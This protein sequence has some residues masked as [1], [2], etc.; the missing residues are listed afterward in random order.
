LLNVTQAR[1]K[2]RALVGAVL[3]GSAMGLALFAATQVGGSTKGFGAETPPPVLTQAG[4]KPAIPVSPATEAAPR[5]IQASILP[6]IT[7]SAATLRAVDPFRGAPSQSN[8]APNARDLE[9]LTEAIYFESRGQPL[10]GQAAVAQVILNRS[11]HPAYP[12]SVCGVIYQG[13]ERGSCQF[14]FAC[15]RRTALRSSNDW[16]VAREIATAALDGSARDVVGMATSFHA[17]RV[18]PGWSGLTR[19]ATVGSHVFYKFSGERGAPSAFTAAPRPSRG[20]DVSPGSLNAALMAAVKRPI[21]SAMTVQAVRTATPP[22]APVL[23]LAPAEREPLVAPE[24]SPAPAPAV[25]VVEP[26]VGGA[27]TLQPVGGSSE[28]AAKPTTVS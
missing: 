5:V 21:H 28:P 8:G 3:S 4:L 12:K 20:S 17:T 1:A 22:P 27:A 9:C 6:Q 18:R 14:S 13:R 16:T 25:I 23:T 11:R 2:V 15:H 19:V 26:Q 10:A 7:M 24:P